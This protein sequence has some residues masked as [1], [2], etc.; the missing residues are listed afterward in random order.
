MPPPIS[1]ASATFIRFSITSILSLTLAPPMIAT[2]GLAGLL[3]RFAEVGQ[4]F[5]HQQAR[6]RLLD[7]L[8][9]ADNRSVRAMR[10]AERIANEQPIAQPGQLLGERFVVLLF[11][12]MEAHVFE[13]QNAAVPQRLA[14]GL[15]VFADAITG[16]ND[17]ALKQLRKFLRHRR[18]RILRVRACPWAVPDATRAPGV[19]P[20][21][22][23]SRI[24]GSVSRM[25]VSSVTTP[26]FSG[27]LKSTRMK[28]RLPFRSRSLMESLLTAKTWKPAT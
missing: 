8:G 17:R 25:R 10:G 24:V 7:E 13:Q 28:T 14:L 20:F 2:N 9:D 18:Q 11:L 4:L 21:R 23:A 19:A 22:T 12:R 6:G 26:S 27:T 16:E 15:G 1:I 5:L 3:K